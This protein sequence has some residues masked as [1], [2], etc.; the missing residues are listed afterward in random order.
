[1]AG[2]ADVLLVIE[3]DEASVLDEH[4]SKRGIEWEPDAMAAAYR[5]FTEENP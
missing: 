1:M 4:L 5:K 3:D 2:T